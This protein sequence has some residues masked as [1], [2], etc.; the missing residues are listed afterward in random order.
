MTDPADRYASANRARVA[1]HVVGREHQ[2][3]DRN[4]DELSSY[5]K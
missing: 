2:L 4:L 3:D 5:S 1:A